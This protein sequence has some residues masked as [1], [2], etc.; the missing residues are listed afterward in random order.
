MALWLDDRATPST[1]RMSL[2]R[3]GT[4]SWTASAV[5]HDAAARPQSLALAVRPDGRAVAV[6]QD[7]RAASTD[8]Y[9]AEYSPA[10]ESWGPA[11]LVSDDPG[12]AAQSVPAV[13]LSNTET[14]LAYR[15]DRS[16]NGD[17]RAARG[18]P[19]ALT[20]SFGWSYDGLNRTTAETGLLSEAFTLDGAS[21][22]TGRAGTAPARPFSYDQANRLTS[23]GPRAYTWNT[24]DRL[25]ARGADTF[26][27]DPLGRQT[28]ST[29][30]GTARSYAYNADGL[31]QSR[32]Q[33]T[34]TTFLWDPTS[35]VQRLVTA[36]TDKV[37]YGLGPLYIAKADG[38]TR[39]LARDGQKSVRAEL[40]D[41]GLVTAA[42]RY[43]AYGALEKAS[44]ATATPSLLAYSSQLLDPSG[45]YYLRARWYDPSTGR[46]T[47]RDPLNGSPDAPASLN[48]YAYARANPL[49][50]S[51]P[52]GSCSDPAPG[53]SGTRYCVSA[54]IRAPIAC[55]I[56]CFQGNGR[57]PRSGSDP[58]RPDYKLQFGLSGD[59]TL[60]DAVTSSTTITGTGI[61][62][63]TQGGCSPVDGGAS[64]EAANPFTPG[65]PGIRLSVTV[66][67][68]GVVHV[69]G[70]SYP[71]VE[72][73]AY[74][75]D[76][77][78]SLLLYSAENLFCAGIGL[79]PIFD[80]SRDV[81]T[82]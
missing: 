46:F 45:L 12:S 37:V 3:A 5:I 63:Q 69:R 36:G 32:T 82:D 16:G 72:I 64:C 73:W 65:A 33:G 59:G 48:A 68:A 58:D 78:A 38:T 18:T 66:S 6:W 77:S 54:F 67:P 20:G 11:T 7:A 52:S 14:A 60:I 28:A 55:F 13:A 56:I 79:W 31:L 40:D 23:D 39:T 10:T 34:A 74:Y 2:R 43:T 81:V 80:W 29:V 1:I 17:V 8:I 75:A 21:N 15:D 25:T 57:G 4:T 41:A 9:G 49:A 70:S 30:G 44:P 47:S 42:F 24:A 76:G 62:R 27:Y 51:D 22:L 53:S 35:A 19:A 71:S 61:T 50:M 26:G